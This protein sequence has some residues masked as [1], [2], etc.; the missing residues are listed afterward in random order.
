MLIL[1]AA[2]IITVAS[3][4][5]LGIGNNESAVAMQAAR[6]GAENAATAMAVDH[7]CSVDIDGISISSGT[8][9]ID[10]IA[11]NSPP[12][13][14]TWDNFR[15]NVIRKNIHDGALRQIHGALLGSF[16][17]AAEPVKTGYRTYDVEVRIKRVTR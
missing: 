17:A 13:I 2:I 5:Y 14:F 1:T 7:G 9:I 6:E 10:V 3:I 16:P 11:S 12:G 4:L 15:E 8:I